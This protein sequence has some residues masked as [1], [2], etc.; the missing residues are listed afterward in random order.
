MIDKIL[1]E[2]LTTKGYKVWKI[3]LSKIP[4][5]WDRPASSSGKYHLKENGKV[6]SIA[7]HTYEMLYAAVKILRMFGIEGKGSKE[8]DAILFGIVLHDSFKYGI[9]PEIRKYTDNTHDKIVA[10]IVKKNSKMFETFLNESQVIQLEEEVRFHSGRWSSDAKYNT[11][12]CLESL[13]PETLFIHILDM[14]SSRN[15]LKIED[16]VKNDTFKY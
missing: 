12:F 8:E 1:K 10:D 3:I 5:V 6:P 9:N 16:P 4:Y 11:E 7:E 2:E 14:L 13:Q 15:L